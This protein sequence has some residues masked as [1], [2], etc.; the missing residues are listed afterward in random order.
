MPFFASYF[1]VRVNQVQES[2]LE[3]S[4]DMPT[5]KAVVNQ[6]ADWFVI[7]GAEDFNIARHNSA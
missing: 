7:V 5:F 3:V 4:E 6:K 2:P 1:A